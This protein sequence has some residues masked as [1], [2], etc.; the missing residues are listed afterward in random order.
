MELGVTSARMGSPKEDG[1]DD[2]EQLPVPDSDG[3]CRFALLG[4]KDRLDSR[5][6]CSRRPR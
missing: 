3:P 4:P 2:S 5:A 1:V 6:A